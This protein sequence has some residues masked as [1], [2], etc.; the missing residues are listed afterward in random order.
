MKW[1]FWILGSFIA[2]VALVAA[3][4]AMLPVNH[5]ATRRA[6]FRR[7]PAEVWAAIARE[8]NFVEDGVPYEVV[9]SEAPRK[10]V[11]RITDSK[12]PYG[13]TWTQE[14]ESAPDGS[15]LRITED[16]AVYNPIFRFVSRYIMGHTAT[17]DGSLR[18]LAKKFGEDLHLED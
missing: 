18:T 15:W 5:K 9:E 17:I 2:V 10:L 8:K 14:I 6:R 7:Q 3:A 1:V 11:T 13:G 4:G 12:L 16:G